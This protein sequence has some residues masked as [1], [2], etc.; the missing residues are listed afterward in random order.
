MQGAA[1]RAPTLPLE[2]DLDLAHHHHPAQRARNDYLRIAAILLP[3]SSPALAVPAP[4]SAPASAEPALAWLADVWDMPDYI[5]WLQS[6]RADR[7]ALHAVVLAIALLPMLAM[8]VSI[9]VLSADFYDPLLL[10]LASAVAP[11]AGTVLFALPVPIPVQ[12]GAGLL[13]AAVA[14]FVAVH[15]VRADLVQC[16]LPCACSIEY[17]AALGTLVVIANADE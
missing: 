17:V 16:L 14:A 5:D 2:L 7:I 3:P 9:P 12:A 1:A 10:V 6:T 8:R 11:F 13:L 15:A 4:A